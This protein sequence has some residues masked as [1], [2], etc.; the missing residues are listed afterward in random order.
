[1]SKASKFESIT[2]IVT[3][4]TLR[5]RKVGNFQ[6]TMICYFPRFLF[7]LELQLVFLALRLV[8]I[9]VLVVSNFGREI[10]NSILTRILLQMLQ[11][12][13]LRYSLSIRQQISS[14]GESYI[15]DQGRQ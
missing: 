13:W 5:C 9:L 3:L 12:D 7:F 2:I 10:L 15:Y 6:C 11:S 1:M 14:S 8:L 4:R